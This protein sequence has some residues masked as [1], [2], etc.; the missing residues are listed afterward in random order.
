[1]SSLNRLIYF[2]I[3]KILSILTFIR[4]SEITTKTERS[5]WSIDLQL[6][7]VQTQAILFLK[8]MSE[9]GGSDI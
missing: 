5:F 8:L 3:L 2:V 7:V 4:I 1:M 9:K 6:R